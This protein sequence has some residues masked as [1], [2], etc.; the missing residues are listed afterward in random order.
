MVDSELKLEDILEK[1]QAA[2]DEEHNLEALEL[3]LDLHPADRAVVFNQLDDED[4]GA[5]LAHL[6]NAAMAD[7]FEELPDREALEA[8]ETMPTERLADVLD[9][10]E[11]DE[12]ADLLG[13]L[14]ASRPTWP[15]RKWMTPPRLFLSWGTLMRLPVG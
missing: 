7:L 10:M 2:L 8:A 13:D 1:I 4:Q 14:P 11:P 5:F 6:D 12:A 9:E 3:L 15:L